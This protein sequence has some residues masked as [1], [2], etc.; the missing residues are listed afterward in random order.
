MAVRFTI[1]PTR[2][3]LSDRELLPGQE[4]Q[5]FVDREVLRR[6]SPMVP[7][8]TGALLRSGTDS[9]TIGSGEVRYST[10]YARRW[11]YCPAHFTGAPMRGNYWFERMKQNG[12]AAAILRGAARITGG[13]RK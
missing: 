3:L 6:C 5:K 10:P 9:T 7:L 4:A 11:Y 13:R 2:D 8:Q 12:G 1:R